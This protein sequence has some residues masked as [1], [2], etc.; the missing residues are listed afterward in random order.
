MEFVMEAEYP[1][2]AKLVAAYRSKPSQLGRDYAKA[3]NIAAA[4]GAVLFAETMAGT[5]VQA[6]GSAVRDAYSYVA[7]QPRS[8]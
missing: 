7:A 1:T 8:A 3:A 5:F 6:N 4:S 2:F